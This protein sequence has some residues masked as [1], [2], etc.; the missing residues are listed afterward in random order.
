MGNETLISAARAAGF[1]M[2]ASEEEL[3]MP[4]ARRTGEAAE[5]RFPDAPVNDAPRT[6]DQSQSGG[7]VGAAGV[8]WP[9]WKT[10]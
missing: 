1:A 5:N 6:M 4:A 7:A 3:L 10:A 8:W 2:A 9:F